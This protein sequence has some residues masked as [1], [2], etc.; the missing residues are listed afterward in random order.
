[1]Y[2]HFGDNVPQSIEKE[3]NKLLWRELYIAE[4]DVENGLIDAD[5]DDV[6][7]VNPDPASLPM[8][9]YELEQ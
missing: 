5:F 4:R 1:M 2:V 3:Y 6:L 9:E 7:A 8:S